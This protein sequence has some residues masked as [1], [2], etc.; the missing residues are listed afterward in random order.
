MLNGI[1]KS[2]GLG[3]TVEAGEMNVSWLTFDN[4]NERLGIGTTSPSGDL[5]IQG[6]AGDQARLYI[7]DGDDTG[8]S[9]SFLISVSGSNAS[10]YNR[11]ADATLRLG[12]NDQNDIFKIIGTG[13][14]VANTLVLDEGN[15]GIGTASPATLVHLVEANTNTTQGT[16]NGLTLSNT[17]N[18]NNNGSAITFSSS[19]GA[20][21]QAKIGAIFKDRSGGSEDT[22]LFFGV[23]GGGSYSE[24]LRIES[25]GMIDFVGSTRTASTVTHD[26]YVTMKV[27]GTEY[28]F[29]I[30]S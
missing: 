4:S 20:N 16:L 23:L 13:T 1:I 17:Q 21:S 22:D 14:P 6:E 15:V 24:A 2:V 19:T 5:H 25:T 3:N 8:T 30:G 9:N 18:T 12:T 7:T 29:M 26:S 28:K 27:G 11:R 10:I